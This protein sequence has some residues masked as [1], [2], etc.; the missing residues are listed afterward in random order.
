MPVPG[1]DLYGIRA[2]SRGCAGRLRGWRTL[3][4]G[5]SGSIFSKNVP[6]RRARKRSG[7]DA[8]YEPRTEYIQ[9]ADLARRSPP[10]AQADPSKRASCHP[11]V[12]KVGSEPYARRSCRRKKEMSTGA[13]SRKDP[14][15]VGG[16]H[17]ERDTASSPHAGRGRRGQG[18]KPALAGARSAALEAVA[19]AQHDKTAVR[20]ADLRQSRP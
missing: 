1:L 17:D 3:A 5:P 13:Q 19:L 14:P 2:S 8:R 18:P 15:P 11:A 16:G 4:R 10:V 9:S 6:P 12:V 20:P 7:L